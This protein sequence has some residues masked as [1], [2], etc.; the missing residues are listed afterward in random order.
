MRYRTYGQLDDPPVVDG[1]EAF[2]ALNTRLSPDQLQPGSLSFAQNVR[3]TDGVISPRYGAIRFNSSVNIK[4]DLD[5]SDCFDA[6][7][8]VDSESASDRVITAGTDKAYIIDQTTYN[9]TDVT[10]PYGHT[11]STGFL[12]KTS[13]TTLLFGDP[14][15]AL[16]FTTD[17]T[18]LGKQVMRLRRV[19]E[20]DSNNSF[21]GTA[22]KFEFHKQI[23]WYRLG[24]DNDGNIYIRTRGTSEFVENELIYLNGS[25]Y[26]AIYKV[27]SVDNDLVYIEIPDN[28][29]N[30]P[31]ISGNGFYADP[32]NHNNYLYVYSIQDQCPSASFATWAGNRLIVPVGQDDILISSP[33]STHDF[34]EYNRLTIGST[35]SGFVTAL[36]PMVDDSLV[37]FKQ[38]SIYLV[39]GVYAM[40]TADQGGNLAILRISDQLGCMS[41]DAVQIIGQ[42]VM[43]YNRQGLYALVLNPKGE[44][45]VGLPPQAVRLTDIAVTNDIENQLENSSLQ[46]D[47]ACVHF[48]KG[49]LYLLLQQKTRKRRSNVSSNDISKIFVYSMLL[50]K[51]ES[52]DT[53]KGSITKLFTINNLTPSLIAMDSLNGLLT[54]EQNISYDSYESGRDYFESTFSSRSYR[55]RTHSLKHWKRLLYNMEVTYDDPDENNRSSEIQLRYEFPEKEEAFSTTESMGGRRSLIKL[56]TRA[57]QVYFTLKTKGIVYNFHRL[58]FEASEGSRQTIDR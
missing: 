20:Y 6:I 13:V 14:S 38:N 23:P 22:T 7:E 31:N 21:T 26:E 4:N 10:Y 5:S 35:E 24:R 46:H 47:F 48:H 8:Y 52:I 32:P 30:R 19:N 40:R 58:L 49:R 50:G 27:K 2:G 9:A 45:A 12:L 18:S 33:L 54:L 53:Y 41:N 16:N 51:W 42:E 29:P 56:K 36:E 39:T 15:P 34:P 25:G 55:C 1:D 17:Y 11:I 3:L 28:D 57:D 37:V 43:F 44:G